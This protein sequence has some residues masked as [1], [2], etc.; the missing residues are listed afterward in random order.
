MSGP[1]PG[2]KQSHF[3]SAGVSRKGRG[4]LNPPSAAA[5]RQNVLAFCHIV[6]GRTRAYGVRLQS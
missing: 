2:M 5:V 3:R 1:G 6:S 4:G